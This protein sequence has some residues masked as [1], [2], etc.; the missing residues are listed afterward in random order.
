[1]AKNFFFH[2]TS[3]FHLFF[4]PSS[5]YDFKS[6][7]SFCSLTHVFPSPRSPL[8]TPNHPKKKYFGSKKTRENYETTTTTTEMTMTKKFS[9][10]ASFPSCYAGKH[11]HMSERIEKFNFIANENPF[12]NPHTTGKTFFTA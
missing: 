9:R 3:N 8:K 4:F 12:F 11:T 1:M 10:F 5:D 2:P 7:T 6:H